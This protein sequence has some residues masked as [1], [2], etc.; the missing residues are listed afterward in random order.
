MGGSCIARW[1]GFAVLLILFSLLIGACSS[2]RSA[3]ADDATNLLL[4]SLIPTE[5][6]VTVQWI[7][8]AIENAT[9]SEFTIE[10][11]RRGN[12][13]LQRVNITTGERLR[14]G[15]QLDYLIDELDNNTEYRVVVTLTYLVTEQVCEAACHLCYTHRVPRN[16]IH[17]RLRGED[18]VLTGFN[19]AGTRGM[20]ASGMRAEPLRRSMPSLVSFKSNLGR[21]GNEA[22]QDMDGDGVSDAMDRDDDNDGLMEI[23]DVDQFNQIRYAMDGS[24]YGKG[25]GEK[26]QTAGCPIEQGMPSCHGYELMTNISLAAY[27]NWVPFGLDR[28]NAEFPVPASAFTAYFDGNNHTISG[29]SINRTSSS[30]VGLFGNTETA[31]L[32]NIHLLFDEV[33][34]HNKVGSLVGR[35]DGLILSSVHSQGNEVHGAGVEIGG[36]LGAAPNATI[37][38]SSA[39]IKT[40]GG[41]AAVG[42]LVGSADHSLIHASS[43]RL[44]GLVSTAA[45]SGVASLPPPTGS[46]MLNATGFAAGGLAG[47]ARFARLRHTA[48]FGRAVHGAG[49]VGGLI[50]DAYAAEVH[51]STAHIDGISGQFLAV[52]G[53]LGYAY[54]ARVSSSAA[55]GHVVASFAQRVGGLIGDGRYAFVYNSSAQNGSVRGERDVGGLIGSAQHSILNASFAIKEEIRAAEDA[56]GLLG[57]GE[58]A[59]VLFSYATGG[60][61]RAAREAGGLIGDAERARIDSVNA[62]WEDIRSDEFAGGLIADAEGA[63]INFATVN[64]S[65]VRAYTEDVGGLVGYGPDTTIYA[66][67]VHI[68]R[69]SGVR[70]GGLVGQGRNALINASVYDTTAGQLWSYRGPGDYAGLAG[71]LVGAAENAVIIAA[72][73]IMP[74]GSVHSHGDVGGLIGRGG[75]ADIHSSYSH[76]ARLQSYDASAGGLVGMGNAVSIRSSAAVT[77]LLNASHYAGGLMGPNAT[78]LASYAAPGSLYGTELAGGLVAS[79]SGAQVVSAYARGGEIVGKNAG[80]LVGM[81]DAVSIRSSAAITGLLNASHYAGGLMGMGPNAAILASYATTGSLYGAELAGGL[82]AS[83]SGAQVVSAYARGGEIVGKKT[84]GLVGMGNAVSI[85]SSAAVTGLLN[86]S[87]YAGGLMGMGPNATILASYAATGSLYGAELAGG[88]VASGSGAQV[89]SAY[90]RGGE[91]VG[92]KTGGLL[93]VAPQANIFSSYTINGPLNGNIKGGVVVDA[94]LAVAK[95]TYWDAEVL[96]FNGSKDGNYSQVG[97]PRNTAALRIPTGYRGIYANW[98]N[99]NLHQE[100]LEINLTRWCDRDGNGIIEEAERKEGS[101]L[102]DFGNSSQYPVLSCVAGGV[103]LQ[104]HGHRIPPVSSPSPV[105]LPRPEVPSPPKDMAADPLRSQ[106]WYVDRIGV[107]QLWQRNMTGRGVHI[108]VV[109]DA[110]DTAHEDIRPNLL[111]GLSRNFL[112]AADSPFYSNPLPYDEDEDGHGTAVT[113]ILAARGDNGIG[114]KG[115][116]PQA[117]IYLSNY[118]QAMEDINLGEALMPRTNRTAVISNSWGA[119]GDSRLVSST[120]VFKS[121]VEDA[122]HNGY[123][124]MG[125]NYVFSAGNTRANEDMASYEERLNHRGVITVCAVTIHNTSAAYSNFGPNLWVCAPSGNG[126]DRCR[127]SHLLRNPLQDTSECGIPTTDISGD[128]GYNWDP[129]WPVPRG[130]VLAEQ[131]QYL[132]SAHWNFGGGDFMLQNGSASIHLPPIPGGEDYTKYFSGTSAAAPVVSGVIALLRAEYPQLSWRDIK[133]I[134]AESAERI[135]P[136]GARLWRA[137]APAYHNRSRSYHHSPYYGFGLIDAAAAAGLAADWTALPQLRVSNTSFDHLAVKDANETPRRPGEASSPPPSPP[138]NSTLEVPAASRI[139]FIEWTEVEVR[140]NEPNFGNLELLLISPTGVASLLTQTHSCRIRFLGIF[141]PTSACADLN[142]GFTFGAAAHLGGSSVGKWTLQVS[143]LGRSSQLEWRL[144]FYGHE[145]RRK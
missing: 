82:V 52:G 53:L 86:A 134:L 83:G 16:E 87:H 142:N 129:Q 141:L 130:I 39:Q 102:W 121:L 73:A 63:T 125:V 74:Q 38:Y 65:R 33:R 35:G 107:P 44:R 40:L 76:L 106:Q 15:R 3:T 133:L 131:Q 77:G 138:V 23:T 145:D 42:G 93:A 81:G 57:D 136:A 59:T 36:L 58:N 31:Q 119:R 105:S 34:G 14:T 32:H 98:T 137:G 71:G 56:G 51:H 72:A 94:M 108:S 89:V 49:F 45:E 139:T 67:S 78:I 116:A 111:P 19:Q 143:G 100:G 75:G 118:L 24:G 127:V 91:I 101:G 4:I 61:I 96:A 80:G 55:A 37:E 41:A 117:G 7:N 1:H 47:R 11:F 123:N 112:A 26:L 13:L 64:T 70:V 126:E 50:G 97:E 140:S 79:G 46:G 8:P 92:K 62:S 43:A 124:G 28:D 29:L 120:S 9:L 30:C 84:G 113:G 60:I 6:S 12:D 5:R 69:L 103:A 2:N 109:D 115:I 18:V 20:D 68:A 128:G 95:D 132:R 21:D 17:T 90:A 25:S 144:R 135:D 99:Q 122:L 54:Q 104:R 10:L 110:L 22:A 114:V 27:P 88:L 48:A 85:R 66:A